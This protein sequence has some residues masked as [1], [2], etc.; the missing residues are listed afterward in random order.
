MLT[1]RLSMMIE[2]KDSAV[3]AI[4]KASTVPSPTPLPTSASAIGS[5]PKMSA[6]MGMPISVASGTDH[7]L[8]C[9]SSAV[10]I[11]AGT[12]L[13]IAAPMPTPIRT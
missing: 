6:Y 3:T 7:Q 4:M 1:T 5:V 13:W 12:Q 10:M 9:P 11:S 8:S 2:G